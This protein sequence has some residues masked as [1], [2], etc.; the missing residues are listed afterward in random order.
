MPTDREIDYKDEI[1]AK[2]AE[3]NELKSRCEH[4]LKRFGNLN[5][6]TEFVDRVRLQR[7]ETRQPGDQW[8][9]INADM[10]KELKSLEMIQAFIKKN[11]STDESK[12]ID[13][14]ESALMKANDIL[15]HFCDQK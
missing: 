1:A 12:V 15:K 9:Q 10:E 6:Y 5:K 14:D 4:D 3:L 8:A 7:R 2:K 11:K 13:V